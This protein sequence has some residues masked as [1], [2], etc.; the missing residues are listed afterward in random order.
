MW[1]LRRQALVN[2]AGFAASA[3]WASILG[4][5]RRDQGK[6]RNHARLSTIQSCRPLHTYLGLH[7]L[8]GIIGQDQGL[9]MPNPSSLTLAKSQLLEHFTKAGPVAYSEADLAT[10]L[11]RERQGWAL[12]KSTTVRD[13][14]AF[15]QKH[16]LRMH[17]FRAE[18]YGRTGSPGPLSRPEGTICR[19]LARHRQNG[20]S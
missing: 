3:L 1:G 9:T 8:L 20:C 6:R 18:A 7:C 13:F 17:A 15:L 14:I 10:I 11:E 4:A 2:R 19:R 5:R 12:V 16:G